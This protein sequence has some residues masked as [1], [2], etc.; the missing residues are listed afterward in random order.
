MSDRISASQAAYLHRSSAMIATGFASLALFLGILG[1]SGVISFSVGHR[2]R[3][4]GVR[5][6]LGAQKESIYR[7]VIGETA[8]L[9]LGGVSL[10]ICLSFV[11]AGLLRTLL[12]ATAPWDLK[13]LVLSPIVLG[14]SALAASYLP[15]RRVASVHP[16]EALRAE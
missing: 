5:M 15:A 14:L 7:L 9:V 11:A 10:G 2:T 1:L 13:T 8:L 12:Y 16:S 4:I 6:A 3:E